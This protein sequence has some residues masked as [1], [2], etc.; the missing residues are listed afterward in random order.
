MRNNLLLLSILPANSDLPGIP[1]TGCRLC[2]SLASSFSPPRLSLLQG[3]GFDT[4]HKYTL[5]AENRKLYDL[6]FPGAEMT[7]LD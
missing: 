7:K 1:P 5:E 4:P 6:K 3:V 2:C